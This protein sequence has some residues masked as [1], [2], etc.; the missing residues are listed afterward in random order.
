MS[1]QHIHNNSHLRLCFSIAALHGLHLEPRDQVN[2]GLPLRLLYGPAS[3]LEK[4][5]SCM[6]NKAVWSG[7]RS[8]DLGSASPSVSLPGE[9]APPPSSTL[10]HA[11]TQGVSAPHAQPPL[12]GE[13]P[14]EGHIPTPARACPPPKQDRAG[15]A[16]A[17]PHTKAAGDKARQ[18][19]NTSPAR[20]EPQGEG[21]PQGTGKAGPFPTSQSCTPPFLLASRWAFRACFS[22]SFRSFLAPIFPDR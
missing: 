17:R 4:L 9:A 8:Q 11:G 10:P 6:G 22:S 12:P 7:V 2:Q 20:K 16:W 3:G 14:S 5:G 13:R 21:P 19:A 15:N 1:V 18:V